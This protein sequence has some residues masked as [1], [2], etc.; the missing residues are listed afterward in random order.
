MVAGIVFYAVG[1]VQGNLLIG[2][3]YT[4]SSEAAWSVAQGCGG[5]VPISYPNHN[6]G[7]SY[8]CVFTLTNHDPNF[9]HSIASVSVTG[10]AYLS[11]MSPNLDPGCHCSSP[12]AVQSG[13]SQTVS[14][15]IG[16][17]LPPGQY[18]ASVAFILN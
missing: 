11:S 3:S 14:V 5:N 16:M 13:A 4:G 10:T 7:A 6:T 17:P 12:L 15:T 1:P 2:D 9:S 8:T 18:T